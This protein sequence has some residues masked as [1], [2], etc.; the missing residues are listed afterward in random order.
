MRV[1]EGLLVAILMLNALDCNAQGV[2]LDAYCRSRGH[3]GVINI[4]NTGYGWRCS[5]GNV[6]ISVDDVCVKQYGVG[7]RARLLSP[8]P[9]RA[10]DWICDTSNVVAPSEPIPSGHPLDLQQYCRSVG[11]AGVIN[12]DGTGYGWRC[13]PGNIGISTDDVCRVQYGKNFHAILKTSPPGRAEDWVCRETSR[14]VPEW[15][16]WAALK[17]AIPGNNKMN[18]SMAQPPLPDEQALKNC[19]ASANSDEIFYRCVVQQ[20]VPENYRIT[21][22]CLNNNVGDAGRAFACSTRNQRIVG[23]YDKFKRVKAC[24]DSAGGDRYRVAQCLG[25]ETLGKN[26]RDYLACVTSNRGDYRAAAVC[27]VSKDLT[28]EQQIALS[29]AIETGGVPKAFAICTGGK[30]MARE[31]EKCWSAGVATENGCFGKNN[32]FRKGL[33]A[34][35]DQVKRTFGAQSGVY[36]GY[37]LWQDNVLA[38]GPRHVVIN[39]INT[40]INDIK[41]GRPGENSDIRKGV[42][43]T[44]KAIDGVVKGVANVFHP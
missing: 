28:P 27:A 44:C 9:G 37:R 3:S 34:A 18:L 7:T 5:P 36:Q 43:S 38:P 1:R 20:A 11:Y 12:V 25:D 22:Q 35:D 14:F 24:Y 16:S 15:A 21:Q 4:D 23:E 13:S 29:C 26:E 41:Q 10:G 30:L 31:L 8:P 32:E 19:R 42:E 2:N 39:A 40:G 17:I 6:G 33:T